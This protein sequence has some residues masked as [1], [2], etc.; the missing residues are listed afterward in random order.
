MLDARTRLAEGRESLRALHQRQLSATQLVTRMTT[1]VDGV[2]LDLYRRILDDLGD[3]L[4]ARIQQETA[5]VAVGGYGRRQLAPYSDIDVMILHA[6]RSSQVVAPLARQLTQDVFDAGAAFGHSVR[7]IT[8]AVRLARSDPQVCTC[9]ME[10]R[11]LAGNADLLEQFTTRFERTLRRRANAI[12]A[13]FLQERGAERHQHGESVYMLEPN[14]KRSRGGLRDLHLLRWLGYA[15]YGAGDADAL[16]RLG[17][18]AKLEHHRLGSAQEFL[19][20]LRNELHFHADGPQDVLDRAEQL[21]IAAAFAYRGTRGLL[22]VEQ[23]MRDYFWHTSQVWTLVRRFTAAAKQRSATAQVLAPVLGRNVDEMFRVGPRE[24]TAT[25]VGLDRLRGN[26]AAVLRLVDLAGLYDKRIEAS[27]R[28]AVQLAS[29][30]MSDE[31]SDEV[32]A[33]FMSL[34]SVPNH[35]GDRLRLLHELGVLERVVPPFR[36]ARCLLQFNQYHKYTVDEHC[37]RAVECATELGRGDTPI[38]EA[39]GAIANKRALHLALLLHDLGKGLEEDHSAAGRE[40]AAEVAARLSLPEQ[41]ADQVVWLVHKHLLMSHMAFRRDTSDPALVAQLAEEAGSQE[42]LAMLFVLSCADLAA[43]GP[44][45]LNAWKVEVLAELYTRAKAYLEDG[46]TDTLGTRRRDVE[47]AILAAL[48]ETAQSE[49]WFR[50]QLEGL[51][52]DL[53]SQRSA[54][55]VAGALQAWQKLE[56]GAA[57]AEASYTTGGTLLLTAAVDHG[58]GR[59]IFA[60]FAGALSAQG[61]SILTANIDS[62]ADYLLLFRFTAEDPRL[63]L[64]EQAD[65]SQKLAQVVMESIS[66]SEPPTFQE[67]WGDVEKQRQDELSPLASRVEIDNRASERH[68]VVEVF[69]F[70]RR[71]LLYHLAQRI[72]DRGLVMHVAKIGTYLDQVVDV[73]YVT[74]RGGQKITDASRLETIRGDLLAAAAAD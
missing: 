5:I 30:T 36:H 52:S 51:P 11:Y 66:R 35:L 58:S 22:P 32:I 40:I 56:P 25:K 21:R 50:R 1:L 46:T 23:F 71:G 14:V 70:D 73:F 61:L 38:A 18:L 31:V 68:T 63:D 62:L 24:I 10:T 37:I 3:D 49:P 8:E 42:K 57:W 47:A 2:L 13:A 4:A 65:R 72:H 20:R 27:T 67:I 54:A 6:G 28:A 53:L 12:C 59:G 43:V 9:L 60:K 64:D 48:P 39:Y 45:V 34:L 7:S 55:E 17:V 69:T 16:R 44:D 29:P 15:R 19:L 33:R 74:D 26:L 41:E